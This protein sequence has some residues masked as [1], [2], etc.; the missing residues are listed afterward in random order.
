MMYTNIIFKSSNNK[1]P[2]WWTLR[3]LILCIIGATAV[4]L[5]PKVQGSIGDRLVAYQECINEYKPTLD[6]VNYDAN[7]GKNNII[8]R[9]LYR[10]MREKHVD[11]CID[12]I[13]ELYKF[14]KLQPVKFYGKWTFRK[15][16]G[17]DEPASVIFSF[18]NLIISI[19]YLIRARAIKHQGRG[20]KRQYAAIYISMTISWVASC[21]YHARGLYFLEVIDYCAAALNLMVIMNMII[22]RTLRLYD[23][24]YLGKNTANIIRRLIYVVNVHIY[25][26]HVRKLTSR[27]P[28]NYKYNL[29]FNTII[30]LISG[31]LLIS[32]SVLNYK[33]DIISKPAIPLVL[34][35]TV[36]CLLEVHE[37][38]PLFG[39]FDAHSLWHL[40]TGFTIPLFGNLF[41]AD[42]KSM[43][44]TYVKC[45]VD[46]E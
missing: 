9:Y 7:L 18:I 32:Y 25:I 33:K 26:Y 45:R 2:R 21:L 20:Y 27:R 42:M 36:T 13:N 22:V 37:F 19:Y 35:S 23:S 34:M 8:K 17:A 44:N 1:T 16:A 14:Y 3:S 39:L 4:L 31:I 5:L 38:P 41:L 12:K 6:M 40:S 28:F 10:S 15:Y 11:M 29:Q 43:N 46:S 30:G 24:I